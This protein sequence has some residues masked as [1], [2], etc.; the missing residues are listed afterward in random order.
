MDQCGRKFLAMFYN[1]RSMEIN[2][3]QDGE[4]SKEAC[5]HLQDSRLRRANRGLGVGLLPSKA[6]FQLP[7]VYFLN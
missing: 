5:L 4:Q 2:N 3:H 7:K 1:D 6:R